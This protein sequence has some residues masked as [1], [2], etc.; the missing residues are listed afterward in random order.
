MKN[1]GVLAY[2]ML[3]FGIFVIIISG[4][5]YYDNIQKYESYEGETRGN[6][7]EYIGSINDKIPVLKYEVNKE[8]YKLIDS[9]R[10]ISSMQNKSIKIL[11]KLENPEI[12]KIYDDYQIWGVPLSIFIVGVFCALFGF[13]IYRVGF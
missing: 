5:L 8:K 13:I 11:Y 4:Y 7:V 10:T 6:I 12:A 1:R 2:V 3:A 9:S